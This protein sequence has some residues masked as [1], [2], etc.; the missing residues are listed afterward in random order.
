MLIPVASVT[1]IP[2]TST[3]SSQAA[4]PT[5]ALPTAALPTAALPTAEA[6]QLLATLA[7]PRATAYANAPVPAAELAAILATAR[8]ITPLA[9]RR[10]PAVYVAISDPGPDAGIYRT[11]TSGAL[12]GRIAD[13]GIAAKLT[14]IYPPAPAL[15]LICDTVTGEPRSHQRALMAAA[16]LGYSAWLAAR[17]NGLDGRLFPDASA[18]VTAIARTDRAGRRDL[19][20]GCGRRR[21]LF[22]VALGLAW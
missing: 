20:D 19:A 3:V 10:N 13:A 2:A 17:R 4:L 7:R 16:A 15:L 12:E 6:R 14:G 9:G 21:H 11:A 5:A 8:Q 22:T 18:L 1:G